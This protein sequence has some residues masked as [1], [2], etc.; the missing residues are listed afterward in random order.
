MNLMKITEKNRYLVIPT[1]MDAD[2]TKVYIK[3]GEG[4][5][6]DLDVK[7]SFEKPDSVFYYDLSPFMGLDIEVENS[8]GKSFGFSE[9]SPEP[10][11]DEKRP[12]IHF[13]AP[14]GWINDPNGLCLYEGK[15]HL[16][17][18][19]N[20]VGL[21]WGNMH[22]GHAVSADLIHWEDKGDV[23]YPDE[24]GDMF[25]GSAIVDTDDLLGLKE[26]E[27]DP[28]L[29]FYTANGSGRDISAGKKAV[30]CLAYSTDGG[31]TFK[32]WAKNPVIDNIKGWNRDPKVI[33]DPRSGSYVMALYLDND[34]YMLLTSKNLIDWK[35]LQTI[36]LTGDN[37][38]PDFYPLLDENG[39]LK[40]VLTGAH[41]CA[42]IG[43]FDPENGF[44]NYGEVQKFGF[45]SPY[46][47]QSFNL[48]EDMRRVRIAWNRFTG[49]GSRN[50]NC[51]MG[52]PTEVTLRGGRLRLSPASELD[53][54]FDRHETLTK[55]PTHGISRELTLPCRIELELSRLEETIIINICGTELKLDAAGTISI[56]DQTMPISIFDGKASFELIADKVGIEIFDYSGLSY[57]AYSM[58]PQGRML[59]IGG[60]GSLDRITV[61]EM[62]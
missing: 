48:G 17:Y 11:Y 3:N 34:E 44:S 16:F 22:W 41:D 20:P 29:L 47:A 38:C 53:G 46:A 62:I 43:D 14:R 28:L 12:L 36:R 31:E 4:F 57:G 58:I 45:I 60:E 25:S 32:K 51:A 39:E 40:W 2:K 52:I 13:S 10:I 21:S 61:S 6:L 27:H 19:H 9:L 49:I 35:Q 7:L 55:L 50:F 1:S 24:L 33:R 5:L 23:L 42:L 8:F 15:Y 26:N 59:T 18:Q 54:V 37:E 30:Q 56:G